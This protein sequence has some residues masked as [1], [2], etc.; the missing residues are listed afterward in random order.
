MHGNMP[1]LKSP[2][3]GF[4]NDCA[5]LPKLELIQIQK[6]R[7]L[8]ATFVRSGYRAR[9]RARERQYVQNVEFNC[10]AVDSRQIGMRPINFEFKLSDNNFTGKYLIIFQNQPQQI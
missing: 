10:E 6:P 7:Q 5:G 3:P 9:V 1:I 2:H 8:V 4:Y